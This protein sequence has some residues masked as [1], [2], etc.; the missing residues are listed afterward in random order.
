[1]I[2]GIQVGVF[3]YELGHGN[4]VHAFF[5]TIE[6]RLEKGKWGKRF[7]LT[8]NNLYDGTVENTDMEAALTELKTIEQELAQ[9]SPQHVIWNI[10]NLS[11]RPPFSLD[12][13]PER[14]TNLSN[15]F[16]TKNGYNFFEVFYEAMEA[17]IKHNE[18]LK[19]ISYDSSM[20]IKLEN[21]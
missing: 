14:I 5:S 21:E 6:I 17:A 11:Q 15:F 9:L 8:M 1:M 20:E 4:L 2:F 18:S 16:I 10:E 19:I 13:L 7:P 3:L 12:N